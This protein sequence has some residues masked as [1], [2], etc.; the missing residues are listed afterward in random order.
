MPDICCIGHI[1][2]D[3]IVTIQ[4]TTHL[5]GGTSWYFSNAI[6][7]L[8]VAY[9]LI[10]A[11]ADNEKHFVTALENIGINVRSYP[12]S[13]TI[14]F[15]NN[16][17]ENQDHRTQKV[18]QKADPFT[19]DQVSNTNASIVHLGPLVAD[20]IPTLLIPGLAATTKVS[21]DVQGYLRDVQ[22]QK[23]IPVKWENADAILPFIYY[24][25]ANEHEQEVLTGCTDIYEGAKVLAA[26]GVKEVIITLGSLGSVILSEGQFYTI[27]A[28]KPKAVV[29]ATGCGDTYM[30]GY[31]Y[32][33]VKGA[34]IQEAGEFGAAMATLNISKSGPFTG[35]IEEILQVLQLHNEFKLATGNE[36]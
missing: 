28:Y 32:K 17:A 30:A 36:H 25:K 22:G 5:P 31:L 26:A 1:T 20:D 14:N 34:G 11:V 6:S 9:Q 19:Q 29:D 13:H 8:N 12:S 16:Y 23:V 4:N 33:R 24:L 21:L 35:S 2:L 15:I 18:T 3:E 7:R 10:T 27:P